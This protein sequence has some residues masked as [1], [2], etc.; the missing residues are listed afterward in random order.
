MSNSDG[1]LPPLWDTYHQ[2]S[3]KGRWTLSW[4]RTFLGDCPVKI[5]LCP[6]IQVVPIT[7][8]WT[9]YSIII[10]SKEAGHF[11]AD[12]LLQYLFYPSMG[13]IA[14]VSFQREQDTLHFTGDCPV[15]IHPCPTVVAN[16]PLYM[17]HIASVSFHRKQ[18]TL[19]VTVLSKFTHVQLWWQITPSMGHIASVSFQKEQDTLRVTVLYK[20]THVW[21]WWQITPSMGHRASVSFQREQDTFH[22]FKLLFCTKSTFWLF[23][24]R[25][26]KFSLHFFKTSKIVFKIEWTHF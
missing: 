18:D 6:T 4:L 23:L 8:Y 19:Q 16:Y 24:G 14:S 17:G 15:Q 13:H 7:L 25:Y 26:L 20:V 10:L 22:I 9:H 5:H 2:C 1:K 21:L 11:S 3:F 12:C